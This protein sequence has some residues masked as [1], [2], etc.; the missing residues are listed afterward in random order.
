MFIFTLFVLTAL[1]MS[2]VCANETSCHIDDL[3]Y[4]VNL[5][6]DGDTIDLE[7]DYV[8]QNTSQKHIII[9]TSITVDGHDH[10]IDAGDMS[11][12]FWVRA[13]NVV[14]KNINFKNAKTAG[15]AGGVISWWGSN[16]TLLNCNFTDCIASSAGG[17]L[18][19]MGDNATVS[20]CNFINNSAIVAADVSLTCGDGYEASKPHIQTVNSDGGAVYISANGISIEEC[21]FENNRAEFGG[22]AL[23][24]FQACD[25]RI[26]KSRFKNNTAGH[27]GGGADLSCDNTLI[28]SSTFTGNAPNDLFL[29]SRNAVVEDSFFENASSLD[30]MYD[31]TLNNV[32]F[33]FKKS[34]DEL[35]LQIDRAF[36]GDVL[37]LDSDYEFVNG[38]N[39]G[40]VISKPITIDGMGHTLDGKELSRIFNVTSDNV[41]L[42][43]IRFI[44]GK[45][46]AKYFTDEVGGGALYWSGANGA[47]ENCSFF[48]NTIRDI[49]DDPF[50]KGEEE[51]IAE[52]GRIIHIIRVRPMGSVITEGGAIVWR[53]ENGTVYKCIFKDNGV[54][55]PNYGGAIAWRGDGGHVLESE[56]YKN[57]GWAGASIFWKGKNGEIAGSKFVNSGSIFE[58]DILW[59]AENGTIQHCILLTENGANPFYNSEDINLNSNFII[60]MKYE[61]YAYKFKDSAE[62]VVLKMSQPA[63]DFVK[64]GDLINLE[65]MASVSE[66]GSALTFPVNLT[67]TAWKNGILIIELKGGKPV[68][69]IFPTPLIVSN[70]LTKYYGQSKHFKVRVYDE[71]GIPVTGKSV[72]FKIGKNVFWKKT[73]SKGYATLKISKKPGKYTI[74]VKYGVMNVK[75]KITVKTTL[76]T[77][78]VSK[79]VKKS[80][81]F[82]VKVLK[83]DG[84]K[85]AKKVVKIKFKGK[86]YKIKTNKY[87]IAVFKL[88]KSLKVGKYTI[89]TFCN[90]LTN[91]NRVVVKR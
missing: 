33:G 34:F 77:K 52:D 35:A 45:T 47:V 43:N 28:I 49:D 71:N 55:Y 23:K 53:G 44:N 79:K 9:D 11:R 2:C 31:V 25:L 83:S 80:G 18:C 73:D 68:I 63:S 27:N 48:N 78:N 81:K 20:K 41:T 82:T 30:A 86:T 29:N 6:Q 16:G 40:I 5:T 62:W 32:S 38:S 69:D 46:I 24:A 19:L 13:D 65:C 54:G 4:D 26:S 37:V 39:T 1:S 12:V 70:D 66:N 88:P 85:Y 60:D 15:L 7:N 21:T 90:G 67:K 91:S 10:T 17:A 8:S 50:E 3:A 64:K 76:I 75:N 84:K 87:G 61:D 14:I 42:K 36:E 59:M 58:R 72:R 74:A 22:G 57:N 56:F 51:I 89:K